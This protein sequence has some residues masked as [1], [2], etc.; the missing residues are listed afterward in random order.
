MRVN[1]IINLVLERAI[2]DIVTTFFTEMGEFD[3]PS[4]YRSQLNEYLHFRA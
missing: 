2:Y 3:I 1:Q 4:E